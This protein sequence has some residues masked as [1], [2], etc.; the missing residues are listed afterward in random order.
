METLAQAKSDLM[1]VNSGQSSATALYCV[2]DSIKKGQVL[3][4]EWQKLIR[5]ADQL[6]HGW[7]IMDEYTADDLAEDLEDE[8]RI[9]KAERVAE[10]K[11]AKQ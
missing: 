11:A 10:R 2:Q 7:G 4:E 9:K 5:L 1:D 8:K 3:I 6:N